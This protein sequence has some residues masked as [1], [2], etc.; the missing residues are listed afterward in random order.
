M[1]LPR[2]VMRSS[3][4]VRPGKRAFAF[5]P[6]TH[7]PPPPPPEFEPDGSPR[8]YPLQQPVYDHGYNWETWKLMPVGMFHT[9]YIGEFARDL[10][11]HWAWLGSFPPWVGVPIAVV[12]G[13]IT[14]NLI[15]NLGS[16]GIKPKR[17]TPE[18][19]ARLKDRERAE[20]TNPVTRY[21]DRRRAERGP[22]PLGSDYYP[23]HPYFVWMYNAHDPDAAIPD[24]EEDEE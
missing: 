21:L 20:N 17:F 5:A 13:I 16:I 2:G 19:Q 23:I 10:A 8:K 6:Y 1:L 4:V 9:V 11:P 14:A 15:Q 3:R 12:F 24:A 7:P 22:H 18:W